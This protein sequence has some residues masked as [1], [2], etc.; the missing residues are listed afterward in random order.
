MSAVRYSLRLFLCSCCRK[1]VLICSICDR[2]QRYCC[3]ECSLTERRKTWCRASRSYQRTPQGAR[4]HAKRQSR[5][6]ERIKKVT[7]RG[8]SNQRYSAPSER[9]KQLSVILIALELVSRCGSKLVL[10]IR[11]D[12]H[13]CGQAGDGLTR[14]GFL[15]TAKIPP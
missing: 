11:S 1:Q 15:R 10:E 12:C 2:G 7:H 3:K 14:P 9:L 13:F 8:S 6:R 4:N 5:Y